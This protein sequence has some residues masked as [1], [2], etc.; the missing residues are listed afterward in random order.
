MSLVGHK[1]E[2]M[3]RRYSIV[4]TAMQSEAA[5][6]LSSYHESQLGTVLGTAAPRKVAR[7]A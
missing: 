7:R 6:L 2:A 5:A 1:T 4:G 3:Y